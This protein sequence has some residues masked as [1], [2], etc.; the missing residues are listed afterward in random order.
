VIDLKDRENLNLSYLR[1]ISGGSSIDYK[2][3]DKLNKSQAYPNLEAQYKQFN[4]QNIP[5]LEFK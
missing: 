5:F 3:R 4:K 1:K 2:M